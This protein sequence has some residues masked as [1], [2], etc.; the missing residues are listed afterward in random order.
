MFD[1][2]TVKLLAKR[3]LAEKG[4]PATKEN[5]RKEMRAIQD[6]SKMKAERIPFNSMSR[7]SSMCDPFSAD[8]GDPDTDRY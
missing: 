3:M 5:L 1:Y 6:Q 8:R 2:E 7:E 4:L